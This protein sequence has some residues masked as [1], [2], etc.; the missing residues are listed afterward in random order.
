LWLSRFLGL[1]AVGQ[2]EG[3]DVRVR[4]QFEQVLF[5]AEQRAFDTAQDD[6]GVFT[7][8][9]LE[10]LFV[11]AAAEPEADLEVLRERV[12]IQPCHACLLGAVGT[13]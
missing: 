1:L 3:E 7:I 8:R 10:R 11:R 9:G 13:F 4:W 12:L 6:L 2:D 5:Q